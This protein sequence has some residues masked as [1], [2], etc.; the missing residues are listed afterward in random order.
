MPFPEPPPPSD[1]LRQELT[2]EPDE[3]HIMRQN[4]RD[5]LFVHWSY[6]RETIQATLPRG[7]TVDTFEGRAWVG[8]VPFFMRDVHPRFVPSV[9]FLSNFL[10]LNVRTYVLDPEGRP[11]VWFY[12]LD[13][14][15]AVA[16]AAARVGFFLPYH[17]AEMSAEELPGGIIDY[18]SQ[19][20]GSNKPTRFQYGGHG[21]AR[22]AE[23]GSLDFFL[24]ERYMLFARD[25]ASGDIHCGRV[26]HKPYPLTRPELRLHDTAMLELNGL[27][28]PGRA[29]DQVHFSPGVDVRI[30]MP[31][32]CY[33]AGNL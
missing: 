9:P 14:N 3:A 12:S 32:R 27:A 8:I 22:N 13:C 31:H 7:L 33:Q 21:D 10:E 23:L 2:W 16:V 30:Y 29:P 5:L 18:R 4:W 24:I 1:R 17:E 28:A 26:F 11:G 19:R 25:P 15:N 6:P 20:N